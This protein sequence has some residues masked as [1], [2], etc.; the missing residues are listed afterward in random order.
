MY[1]VS[2]KMGVNAVQC[3]KCGRE[4][5]AGCVFC[6]ECLTEMDK[7]P[8]K[9]GT[10]VTIPK[11]PEKKPVDRRPAVTPE[12][13][14]R[15]LTRRIRI[16]SWVLTL[17]IALLIAMGALAFTMLEEPE[18]VPDIGQNYSYEAQTEEDTET[19]ESPDVSRETVSKADK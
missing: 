13:K 15:T 6:Q 18:E 11:Q 1:N 14:I 16:L 2:V 4:I 5:Y 7:Y 9:P 12:Q 10:V 17:L 3:M 8:I 19:S